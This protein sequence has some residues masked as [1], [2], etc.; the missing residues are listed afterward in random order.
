MLLKKKQDV[1]DAIAETIGQTFSS[2]RFTDLFKEVALS[3]G[4][5]LGDALVTWYSLGHLALAGAAWTTYKEKAKVFRVLDRCRPLLLKHW[6]VS[7]NAADKLRAVVNETEGGAF[8]SFTRCK[9]GTDLS[10]FFA[11]YVSMILGASVPFSER[12]ML[13]DQLMCIKYQGSDLILV[14]SVCGLFVEVCT[15]TK[16]LLEKS[17]SVWDL[18]TP[19]QP[20]PTDPKENSDDYGTLFMQPSDEARAMVTRMTEE[21]TFSNDFANLLDGRQKTRQPLFLQ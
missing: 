7:E 12:S 11:R 6:K 4:W 9:E 1:A 16:E 18:P 8:A 13:E 15:A 17:S 3:E 20:Q 10:L 5:A 14:T 19:K 2:S 21:E